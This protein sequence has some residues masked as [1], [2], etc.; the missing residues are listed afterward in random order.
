MCV[1]MKYV[2]RFCMRKLLLTIFPRSLARCEIYLTIAALFSPRD[3]RL[4]LH[5]TDI[6]DVET[7]HDFFNPCYRM[8]SKGIRV[9]VD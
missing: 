6:T 8:D 1:G 4:K 9:T 2:S 7:P 5:E 3:F